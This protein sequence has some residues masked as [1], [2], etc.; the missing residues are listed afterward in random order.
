MIKTV[1]NDDGS[2]TVTLCDEEGNK[3]TG[4]DTGTIPQTKTGFTK[5]V[6]NVD[7]PSKLQK[8]IGR[9]I[10]VY[11]KQSVTGTIKYLD[12]NGNLIPAED[13]IVLE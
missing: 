11:N 6:N 4:T 10:T 8:L 9:Y 2:Y 1:A 3:I 5:K 7:T 12:V 13:Y